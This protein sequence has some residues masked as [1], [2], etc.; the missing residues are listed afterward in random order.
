M[1]AKPVK[2][3]IIYLVLVVFNVIMDARNV[4]ELELLAVRN[5]N[6]PIIEMEQHHQNV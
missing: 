6:H 2:M 4:L 3:D 5:V 1:N